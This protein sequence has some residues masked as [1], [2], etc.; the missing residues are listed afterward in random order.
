SSS[1]TA[2][3]TPR[4]PTVST[5][6][7]RPSNTMS[8]TSSPN[9]ASGAEPKLLPTPSGRN[10]GPNRGTPRCAGGRMP[11]SSPGGIHSRGGTDDHGPELRGHHGGGALCGFA[12]ADAVGPQ[13]LPGAAGRPVGVPQR[14]AV[15]TPDPR[16]RRRCAEPLGAARRGDG[17]ALPA[18]RVLFI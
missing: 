14:H 6:A 15:H 7:A 9:S 3:R 10:Q 4:S 2:S 1:V 17:H 8:G 12:D 5:S 18:D 16:A 11:A 13:G